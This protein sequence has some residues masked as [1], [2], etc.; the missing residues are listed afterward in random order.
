MIST[1][2]ET[3]LERHLSLTIMRSSASPPRPAKV[4]SGETILAEGEKA[5]EIV[6]VL[7]GMV[8]VAV[9]GT[10]LATLGPAAV[11]GERVAGG[12]RANRNGP[13]RDRLPHCVRPGHCAVGGRP[14]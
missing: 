4:K 10:A 8:E 11:L 5:D 9:G 7:D 2:A 1:A 14:P 12:W 6:L 13:R 3:A